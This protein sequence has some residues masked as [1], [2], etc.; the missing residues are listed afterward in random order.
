MEQETFSMSNRMVSVMFPQTY[1]EYRDALEA[2]YQVATTEDQRKGWGLQPFDHLPVISPQEAIALLFAEPSDPALEA[3]DSG[4]APNPDN[5]DP[6]GNFVGDESADESLVDLKLTL[7]RRRAADR[8]G[9]DGA[10]AAT[11]PDAGGTAEGA[12]G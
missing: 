7:S 9:D 5:Y 10:D 8:T 3:Y 11:P 4:L 6:D 2:G 12:A 1:D